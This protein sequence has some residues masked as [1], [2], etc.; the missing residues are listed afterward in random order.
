V[1]LIANDESHVA[2]PPVQPL[3]RSS[4][5]LRRETEL[6]GRLDA[7]RRRLTAN[8]C[9][10]LLPDFDRADRIGEYWGSGNPHA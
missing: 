8:S 6:R 3:Y 5:D 2:R 1:R 7:I 4:R 10:S 9:T